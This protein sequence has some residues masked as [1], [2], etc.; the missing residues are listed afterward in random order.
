MVAKN[1]PKLAG[2]GIRPPS[3]TPHEHQHVALH[4][5]DQKLIASLPAKLTQALC[6]ET[7]LILPSDSR[8]P[9]V[10]WESPPVMLIRLLPCSRFAYHGSIPPRSH[11]SDEETYPGEFVFHFLSILT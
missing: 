9:D 5:L 7:Y 3:G 8:I 4:D 11:A 2:K 6:R 1:V 10:M